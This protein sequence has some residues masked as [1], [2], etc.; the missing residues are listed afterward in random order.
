MHLSE[1]SKTMKKSGFNAKNDQKLPSERELAF[2]NVIFFIHTHTC[3]GVH[4]RSNRHVSWCCA[5][6]GLRRVKEGL[7]Q[8]LPDSNHYS[9]GKT[10]SVPPSLLPSLLPFVAHSIHYS[11]RLFLSLSL[12]LF[13]PSLTPSVCS[14]LPPSLTPF[15]YPPSLP[16]AGD[17]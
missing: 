3:P 1:K 16:F 4:T 12:P 5:V 8:F 6:Y 17:T 15:F 7:L 2:R 11:F 13:S 10:A 9:V 14:S